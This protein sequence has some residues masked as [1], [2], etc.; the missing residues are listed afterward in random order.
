MM[1]GI[2]T[3]FAITRERLEMD[4]AALLDVPTAGTR[5]HAA[6]AVLAAWVLSLGV[7]VFLHAGVLGGMYVRESAFLLP[8]EI[9]F[10]RIPA[11]YATFLLLTVGLWWLYERLDVRGWLAGLRLGT[12]LGLFTWGA[13]VLGL[14]SISTAPDSLLLGWWAGQGIEMGLAG[15]VLGS[16]RA[17]TPPGRIWLRVTIAVVVL[18][19]AVVTLQTLGIV[20]TVRVS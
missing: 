17:G 3:R 6:S 9:A 14:W 7:D 16:A 19:A 11:G 8:P 1:A 18:F 2:T 15:A 13:L 10:R 4:G 5:R 20:P 12:A